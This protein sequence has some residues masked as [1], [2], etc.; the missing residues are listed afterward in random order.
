MLEM[1]CDKIMLE[2]EMRKKSKGKIEEEK[3]PASK[4]KILTARKMPNE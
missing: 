2:A 1:M 3:K 4:K